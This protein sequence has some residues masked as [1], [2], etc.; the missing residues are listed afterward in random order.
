MLHHRYCMVMIKLLQE[1]KSNEHRQK[2]IFGNFSDRLREWQSRMKR[3]FV[4]WLGIRLSKKVPANGAGF[5][6][7]S[8]YNV[9]LDHVHDCKLGILAFKIMQDSAQVKWVGE[10]VKMDQ[11]R[12]AFRTNHFLLSFNVGNVAY[13]KNSIK[14]SIFRTPKPILNFSAL[15]THFTCT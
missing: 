8:I 10:N 1:S 9:L 7:K 5:H 12:A 4:G 14:N 6:P 2:H 11:D 13:L 3:I 15:T